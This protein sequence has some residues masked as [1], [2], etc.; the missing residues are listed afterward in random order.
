M[1]GDRNGCGGC[2]FVAFAL[3]FGVPLL[4][5]MVAPATVAHIVVNGSPEQAV[6]LPTWRWRSAASL[7]LAV[8]VVRWALSGKGRLR[9]GS[10]PVLR[11]WLGFLTRGLALL[12]AVNAVAFAQLTPGG[13]V[14]NVGMEPLLVTTATGVGVL[15]ALSLW[16]RRPRRVTVGR[17]ARRPP[18]PIAACAGSAPRTNGCAATPSRC[19]HG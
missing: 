9:G 12:A 18:R 16:D 7:P 3:V 10:T 6:H 1:A 5:L 14:A 19:G 17:C 2:A 11:R 8:L 15:I 4:M 13:Q